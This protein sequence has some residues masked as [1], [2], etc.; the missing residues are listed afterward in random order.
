MTDG[1]SAIVLILS[2][3]LTVLAGIFIMPAKKRAGLNKF[4][5]FTHDLFNFKWLIL[6]T[7]FKYL[8][9]FLTFTVILGG[10]FTMTV[11]AIKY[12]YNADEFFVSG[13]VAMIV[14]PIAVR[15]AYELLMMAILAVKNIIS[16]NNKLK[17][18]NEDAPKDDIFAVDLS[19]FVPEKPAA[20]GGNFCTNCGAPL[21]E[22]N[23][24][25]P[26]CGAKK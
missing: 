11:M 7:I 18:Q 23:A 25:C 6:E 1:L 26:N 15:I 22:D 13:L 3:V 19:E 5:K 2:I 10:F 8:Y 9:V 24:F 20:T 12:D 21:A 14:G 4:F 16:I 17:N